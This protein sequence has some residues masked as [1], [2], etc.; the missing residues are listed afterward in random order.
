MAYAHSNYKRLLSC[1]FF[2]NF[3]LHIDTIDC[4]ENDLIETVFEQMLFKRSE[5]GK[6]RKLNC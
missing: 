5:R 3:A 4:C 6:K 2:Y 1:I